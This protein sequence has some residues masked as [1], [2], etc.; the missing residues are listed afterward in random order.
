MG[1][2][3]EWELSGKSDVPEKMA[4]AKASMEGLEGAAN[5]LSKKFKEAFKDIALGFV[6]PMVLVQKA[7]SFMTDQ[8]E[9]LKQFVQESRQFAKDAEST[10]YF[11][12]G[13]REAI[14]QSDERAK[15]R[16]MEMK[17]RVGTQLGYA[18][19]L[20]DDPRGREMMRQAGKAPTM[21]SPGAGPF[22]FLNPIISAIGLR[23][24]SVASA[25][26]MATD[27]AIRAKIDALLAEDIAKR[28]AG[29]QAAKAGDAGMTASKIPELA[30]NVIGVGMSP[31]LD[32][33]NKQLTVQEDM[34]N[35]L[36]TL[37][38]RDQAQSGFTP[39]KFFPSSRRL[40]L[41]R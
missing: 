41:P 19:F 7:L 17:G 33:A 38:E 22:S 27:P 1:R 40:N 32:I 29:E 3:L 13:A 6:A 30:S 36:R 5:G 21:V 26:M 37:I 18:E 24:Q 35:S 12:A 20:S 39:E 25:Q 15:K 28:A 2:K 31:Q 11:G 8:F 16:E 10:K 4:K 9:K 23:A 34:A 14:L